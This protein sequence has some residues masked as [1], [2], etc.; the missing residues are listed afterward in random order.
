MALGPGEPI[1]GRRSPFAVIVGWEAGKTSVL[2][3][4]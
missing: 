4:P 3:R 1:D 2:E